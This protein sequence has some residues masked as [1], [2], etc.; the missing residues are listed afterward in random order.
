M[1][2]P[3]TINLEQMTV[4]AA[5]YG[6]PVALVKDFKQFLKLSGSG[7]A[8]PVIRIFNCA[9]KL[10]SSINVSFSLFLLINYLICD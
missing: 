7:S 5:S 2:W 10:I 6:G 3:A 4:H 8:K 1:D 9:G